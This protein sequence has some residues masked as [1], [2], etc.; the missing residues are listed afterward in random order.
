M[1][2]NMWGAAI[3]GGVIGAVVTAVAG[4]FLAPTLVRDTLVSRPE[5]L[6]DASNALQARQHAPTINANRESSGYPYWVARSVILL[7]DILAEKG[8]LYNARAALEALLENYNEDPELVQT[9]RTKLEQ[10][11]TLISRGSRLDRSPEPS[12]MEFD[13][14][15]NQ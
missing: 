5:I 9:A 2:N 11:E 15:S 7:S 1:S 8:D 14:D 13:S 3:A 10:L 4:Y 12:T 6:V